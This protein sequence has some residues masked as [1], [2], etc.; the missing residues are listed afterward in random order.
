M[1]T[2]AAPEPSDSL[3]SRL[4]LGTLS[5]KNGSTSTWR[6]SINLRHALRRAKGTA[7]DITCQ[8]E[9]KKDSEDVS[10]TWNVLGCQ[11]LKFV[12]KEHFQVTAT[13][14]LGAC[15][16][17]F[18]YQV[19]QRVKITSEALLLS[20]QQQN[21]LGYCVSAITHGCKQLELENVED[22]HCDLHNQAGLLSNKRENSSGVL[23]HVAECTTLNA[24]CQ[25]GEIGK[26]RWD[27][28]L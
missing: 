8:L 12:L 5:S 25:S 4:V 17:I 9:K 16:E 22:E 13:D 14:E 15:L 3:I 27:S 10:S 28:S 2:A 1:G 6:Y 23:P 26:A 20:I 21:L 18:T 24:I 7:F 11:C 19:K